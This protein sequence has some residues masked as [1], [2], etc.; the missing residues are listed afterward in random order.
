M[1]MLKRPFI[2]ENSKLKYLTSNFLL[3]SVCIRTSSVSSYHFLKSS[4]F[5][6]VFSV[7]IATP[8][9]WLVYCKL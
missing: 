6:N 1:T 7:S 2:N 3:F 8:S 5:I 9:I 4:R